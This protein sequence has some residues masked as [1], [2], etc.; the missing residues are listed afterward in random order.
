MPSSPS[1]ASITSGSNWVPEQRRSKEHHERDGGE[2]ASGVQR[3]EQTTGG[4][5]HEPFSSGAGLK[6]ARI[7]VALS[8]KDPIAS[9]Q[10]FSAR[11]DRYLT[12]T[13]VQ[14]SGKNHR[15]FV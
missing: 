11:L 8:R 12:Q 1:N 9:F 2:R 7:R 5:D 15:S 10:L 13:F 14:E 6:G 4:N 3:A